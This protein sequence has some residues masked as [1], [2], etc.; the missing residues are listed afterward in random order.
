[1]DV[2]RR[3]QPVLA[4]LQSGAPWAG[5]PSGS[6]LCIVSHQA[7]LRVLYGCLMVSAQGVAPPTSGGEEP[8][9]SLRGASGGARRCT[10]HRHGD[11]CPPMCVRMQGV[12][13]ERIPTLDIPLHTLIELTIHVR[14]HLECHL[15]VT[16][17]L[18]GRRTPEQ[19]PN[20]C[21]RC[22]AA[23]GRLHPRAAV[24]GGRVRWA[25]AVPLGQPGQPGVR[26]LVRGSVALLGRRRA[27]RAAAAGRR[28]RVAAAR[29]PAQA[30]FPSGPRLRGGGGGRGGGGRRWRRGVMATIS[31]VVLLLYLCMPFPRPDNDGGGVRLWRERERE[32]CM[33]AAG[34]HA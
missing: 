29:V 16:H 14:S 20:V 19:I 13:A 28:E 21:T 26:R 3:L 18:E 25:G 33:A 4:E 15:G 1:M 23:G 31:F 9:H 6:A 27:R 10:T 34:T 11:G 8:S 17:G 30:G 32:S 24:A 5:A 7:V 2:Q 12:P 22:V